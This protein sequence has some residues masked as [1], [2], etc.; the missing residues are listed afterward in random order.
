M[1]AHHDQVGSPFGRAIED[2]KLRVA[3]PEGC[4]HIKTG[5]AETF[6]RGFHQ[7]LS[8]LRLTFNDG[9]QLTFPE[10]RLHSDYRERGRHQVAPVQHMEDEYLR[11]VLANLGEHCADRRLGELRIVN[12][13]QNPHAEPRVLDYTQIELTKQ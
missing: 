7:E 8:F 10:H 11:I 3:L 9:F 2:N 13:E 4:A 6:A 1:G 5:R 12:R